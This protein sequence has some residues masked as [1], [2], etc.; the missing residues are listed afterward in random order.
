MCNCSS[1]SCSMLNV[2]HSLLER[3]TMS[4]TFSVYL[5][6]FGILLARANENVLWWLAR[7]WFSCC[8]FVFEHC[9]CFLRMALMEGSKTSTEEQE[10]DELSHSDILSE[11]LH[12][13]SW[14]MDL[15]KDNPWKAI[16]VILSLSLVKSK[17][18]RSGHKAHVRQEWVGTCDH[19]NPKDTWKNRWQTS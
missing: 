1:M 19:E 11:L 4:E 6:R 12:S 17:R 8:V 18:I 9:T 13:F 10:F 14:I 16:V 7:F 5:W 2:C 3:W 15:C